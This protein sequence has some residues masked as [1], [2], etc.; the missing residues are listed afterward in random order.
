MLDII[1]DLSLHSLHYMALSE[2][3]N[4]KKQRPFSMNND[5]CIQYSFVEKTCFH[6]H[7]YL[8]F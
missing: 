7:V 2:N 5:K 8:Y 3:N 1:S 4:N 6:A